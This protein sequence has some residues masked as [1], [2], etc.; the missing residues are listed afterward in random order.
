MYMNNTEIYYKEKYLKYKYKYLELKSIIGG[1]I[2]MPQLD[3]Y[4]NLFKRDL[5]KT[6]YS[7]N[8]Q[9]TYT[10]SYPKPIKGTSKI[11]YY[12]VI[13]RNDNSIFKRVGMLGKGKF[14]AVIQY[15]NPKNEYIAVKY[16]DIH[17]DIRVIEHIKENKCSKYLVKYI[18]RKDITPPHVLLWKM[19]MEQLR[20]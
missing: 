14:G 12:S 19:Q 13:K 15:N 9:A 7:F 20:N 10:L 11:K 8:E 6:H 2:P 5:Y 3:L 18:V 17:Q 1:T 4:K 16:G